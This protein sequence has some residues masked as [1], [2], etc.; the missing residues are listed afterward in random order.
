[1]N[2]YTEQNITLNP[3]QMHDRSNPESVTIFRWSN[4]D[5][6]NDVVIHWQ[7][8]SPHNVWHWDSDWFLVNEII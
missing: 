8:P 4:C 2:I 1:M 5:K 6:G 3:P 7:P